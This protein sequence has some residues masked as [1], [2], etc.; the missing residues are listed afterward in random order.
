MNPSSSF[1]PHDNR[2]P[3]DNTNVDNMMENL[4][5]SNQQLLQTIEKLKAENLKLQL[6]IKKNQAALAYF[7]LLQSSFSFEAS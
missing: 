6:F 2:E 3:L 4:N 1:H 7:Y 5:Q